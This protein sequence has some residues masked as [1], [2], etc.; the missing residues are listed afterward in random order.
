[1]F[2]TLD[3]L[4]VFDLPYILTSSSK[5]TA[6]LSTYVRQQLVDFQEVGFGSAASI[7]V[8]TLIA[9]LAFIY[10]ILNKKNLGIET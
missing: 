2:R 1:M 3:A 8:F 9:T 4:R 7:V 6:V 10:L 5:S